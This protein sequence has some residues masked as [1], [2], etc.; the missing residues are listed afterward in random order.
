[1]YPTHELGPIARLLNVTRGNRLVSLVSVASKASGLEEYVE[2]NKL[3]EKDPTLKGAKFKQGD[4]VNT[5]ITCAGGETILLTLDTTLP[6]PYYSREF[7][8][9]GTK[10]ACVEAS[11]KV[12]TWFTDG[13]EEGVFDN[14]K[15]F[16]EKYDH[17]LHKE[18]VS[19]G[20]LGGHGGIDWL[21]VRAF[22]ESVKTQTEPPIDAYDTAAWLAIG[23]LAEQSIAQGGA[24]VAV[25]DFTRG[26][27]FRRGPAN[28]SKYSLDLV[29]ED[30]DMP[31]V[32]E[33]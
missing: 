32:P 2:N 27:W 1:M 29:V 26:K 11:G 23:P 19:I 28:A 3:Y 8:V 5:V 6:R 22:I 14:E 10:G 7:T 33:K 31:I 18:Y 9:R 25:P 30:P 21:V 13:M 12:C 17:P 20:Q 4:V 24:P 15:E 16:F